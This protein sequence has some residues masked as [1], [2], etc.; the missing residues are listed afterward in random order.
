M[1]SN[2]FPYSEDEYWE[3][4]YFNEEWVETAEF[5]AEDQYDGDLFYDAHHSFSSFFNGW[6]VVGLVMIFIFGYAAFANQNGVAHDATQRNVEH[7]QNNADSVVITGSQT[8][9]FAPYEEYTLTQG[10]HGQSYGHLA[11]DIAA[12]R[13][14]P[15]LSPVNGQV[16][17]RY[18]DEYD[19]TTLV[20]EN[21]AYIVTLLHGEFTV[22]KGDIIEIGDKIGGES[23][24]GY[25]MDM[26]GNLCYGREYC[27][28]HTHLN[29]YDKRLQANV[30]PLDLISNNPISSH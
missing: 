16:T 2:Y 27:G 22:N 25:T 21:E 20:I 11:I 14:E 1:S 15:I 7:V 5:F 10:L 17:E 29:I 3:D 23:N 24:K 18:I 6:T 30:N 19:N 4:D 12:G 8:A 26:Q 9:V 13:G 28:N